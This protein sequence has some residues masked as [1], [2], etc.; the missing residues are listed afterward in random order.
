MN[1]INVIDQ[2]SAMTGM[3]ASL[4]DRLAVFSMESTVKKLH[5]ANSLSKVLHYH[6]CETT[7]MRHNYFLTHMHNQKNK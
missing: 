6:H 1:I 3:K 2:I 4:R 7:V 5:K